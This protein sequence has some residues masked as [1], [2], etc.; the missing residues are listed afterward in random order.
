MVKVKDRVLDED[1]GWWDGKLYYDAYGGWYEE[2]GE[3]NDGCEEKVKQYNTWHLTL[4]VYT[5]H[6]QSVHTYMCTAVHD[7]HVLVLRT[8]NTTL[9]VQL[10]TYK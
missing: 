5:C 10:Y 6:V 7:I 4:Y 8:T 2:N 3:Y 1:G 9:R